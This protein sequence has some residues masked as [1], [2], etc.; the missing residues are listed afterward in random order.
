MSQLISL[1]ITNRGKNLDPLPGGPVV[2]GFD[3]DDIVTPIRYN[4]NLSKSYFTSRTN[5][6]GANNNLNG[7]KIDYR[8]SEILSVIVA[9]SP[10]LVILT[11]SERRGVPTNESYIFVASKVSENFV[12][13]IGGGT[14]FYYIEEGDTLPVEYVVTETVAAII[15][16]TTTAALVF[17]ATPTSGS[18]NPVYSG[19]IYSWAFA[20]FQPL[21]GTT[22][23]L[24]PAIA[25]QNAPPGSPITGD[26]YLVGTVPSGLWVG[27]AKNIAEWSGS[28]WVFTAPITD[29]IIFLSSTAQ[30]LRYNGTLWVAWAGT[31]VLHNGN[32]LS[33][34]LVIGTNNAQALILKT[35][36]AEK[37]RIT[38]AGDIGIGIT[39]PT[40]KVHIKGAGSTAATFG[41]KIY[42]SASTPLFSIKNDGVALFS[43][44]LDGS[45]GGTDN[46]SYTSTS[47][48][49]QISY[50]SF[51]GSASIFNYSTGGSI[52][53]AINEISGFYQI[54][55][56]NRISLKTK[57]DSKS[58][59]WMDGSNGFIGIGD[60][61]FVASAQL[62]VVGFDSTINYALKIDN[63]SLSS[64]LYIKNDGKIGMQSLP[65]SNA[66]LLT[67]D[68]YVDTA[69]NI[70]ANGDKI[71]GWKV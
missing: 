32:T 47:G 8:A 19:G 34:S 62:H 52:G 68:L 22:T 54:A 16:Q 11:V 5:K 15:A 27:K 25:Q 49:L 46:Y 61:Y 65:S 14:K 60:N 67:G 17:D 66:G 3:V 56:A 42:N 64:L 23:D 70:L 40:A 41:L 57:S 63:S 1:T 71:V 13:M 53:T 10:L 6:D 48:G 35:N 44:I 55:S 21:G 39:V 59:F 24:D 45:G 26:R 51:G 12:P 18:L 2:Y 37:L 7:S 30:T 38:T 36:N 29:N 31:P 20:N 4:S 28:A 33:T 50:N 58:H 43:S 9:K 69:A